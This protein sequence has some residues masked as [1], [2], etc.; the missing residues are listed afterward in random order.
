MSL[1]SRLFGADSDAGPRPHLDVPASRTPSPD[2]LRR[3]RTIDPMADLHWIDGAGVEHPHWV[4]G[5]V[6]ERWRTA[7]GNRTRRLTGIKMMENA[8]RRARVDW[9]NLKLGMLMSRDFSPISTWDEGELDERIVA[10]FR[11]ADWNWKHGDLDALL[12][13][14]LDEAEGLPDLMA[15]QAVARE[16]AATEARDVYRYTVKGRRS[17]GLSHRPSH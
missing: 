9:A 12:E 16:Y 1:L 3:L 14:K 10:E 4:L 11:E 17:F 7:D 5:V 8:R 2:I 13:R 6:A 15:R